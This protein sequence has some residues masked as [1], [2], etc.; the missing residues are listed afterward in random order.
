ML[1]LTIAITGGAGKIGTAI[2]AYALAAGLSVVSLD[3]TET[4]SLPTQD[5]YSHITVDLLDCDAFKAAV[6]KAKCNAIVHLA[7]RFRLHD[8]GEGQLLSSTAEWV[9][10]L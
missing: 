10:R 2:C 3:R 6:Q 7:A 5:R 9:G 1:P 4:G 8:H